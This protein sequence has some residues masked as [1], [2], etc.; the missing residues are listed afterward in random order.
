MELLRESIRRLGALVL[1]WSL[2]F[3]APLALAQEA[4]P[5]QNAASVDRSGTST[6]QS[7]AAQ[8]HRASYAAKPE[9]GQLEGDARILHALN[10][11][12]FGPKP[13]DLEAV[14]VIGLDKWL[15]AQLHP[16]SLDETDLNARLAQYP[17]M[18]WTTQNLMFRMPSPA[19][20]RQA[21]D[22]KIEIPR[23]GTLHAVYENQIY[24]YQM[25][26]AAQAEKQTAANQGTNQGQ[27]SAGNAQGS[28]MNGGGN[29]DGAGGANG[30]ASANPNMDTGAG[31]TPNAGGAPNAPTT[32]QPT[33]MQADG[34]Q[35]DAEPPAMTPAA[36]QDADRAGGRPRA[37]SARAD[38][39][40]TARANADE[41]LIADVLALQPEER[42]RGC[43]RCSRRSSK[44]LSNR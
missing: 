14:R 20:I 7:S 9:P 33:G 1:C 35:A 12:T 30:N 39:A 15:D 11:L 25:K 40:R 37:D 23:G 24:R 28:A 36:G 5:G 8:K 44:A 29:M 32:P 19:I 21:A 17:A 26:K 13:G 2:C 42:V 3:P 4:S 16:E 6:P 31:M 18:Q 41:A 38:Q 27:D 43:R 34:M 22:G 10:R